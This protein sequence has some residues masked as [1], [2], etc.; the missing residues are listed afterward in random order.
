MAANVGKQVPEIELEAYVPS[1]SGPERVRFSDCRGSWVVLFF[2]PRDFT[3]ICPTELQAF[4]ELQSDFAGEDAVL[5]AASTDSYWSHKAWFESHRRWRTSS[6]RSSP[7]RRN[8]SA[9]RSACSSPTARPC[10][11]RS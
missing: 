9:R 4:A 6:T 5:V 11:A 10:A 7:T 1:R 2:Y 8:A 3:F